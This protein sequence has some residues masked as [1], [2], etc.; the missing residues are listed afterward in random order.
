MRMRRR[1]DLG[2]RAPL[3]KDMPTTTDGDDREAHAPHARGRTW[4]ARLRQCWRRLPAGARRHAV[5]TIQC[6][7]HTQRHKQDVNTIARDYYGAL[8][9][10]DHTADAEYV[11]HADSWRRAYA[12]VYGVDHESGDP[13]DHAVLRRI[14]ASWRFMWMCRQPIADVPAIPDAIVHGELALRNGDLV[15]G[16]FRVCRLPLASEQDAS[17]PSGPTLSRDRVIC[18]ISASMHF[19][20]ARHFAG[21][22]ETGDDTIYGN[23][24]TN[25]DGYDD[26]DTVD[27]TRKVAHRAGAEGG[28]AAVDT[29]EG[30]DVGDRRGSGTTC[31]FDKLSWLSTQDS[32]FE[33]GGTHHDGASNAID[34]RITTI[35]QGDIGQKCQVTK[36]AL[37]LVPHGHAAAV[38]IDG[39]LIEGSFCMGLLHGHGRTVDARGEIFGQWRHGRLHG[40]AV[41]ITQDGWFVCATWRDGRLMGDYFAHAAHGEQ[42][43]CKTCPDGRFDGRC[44]RGYPGGDWAIERWSDGT[45]VG[46]DGFRIA[47]V[48]GSDNLA[49]GAVLDD[50]EWT[51]D[52]V[53]GGDAGVRYDGHIYYPSDPA[54]QAFALFYNYMASEASAR[55][56][57]DQQ[58]DA[59][60]WAMWM[61]R[62]RH[63]AGLPT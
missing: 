57:T 19:A 48:A 60:V 40:R 62:R 34:D 33:C 15:R 17:I 2:D 29:C 9:R 36:A 5:D 52:R 50:C 16:A 59:F 61:A 4:Y 46:I 56:F 38:G 30:D 21:A 1:S 10:S 27:I 28:T 42:F 18:P 20:K 47:P 41:A 22:T 6:N 45:L 63:A 49:E 44:R 35:D 12:A 23:D 54:S 25:G 7:E 53:R 37:A 13:M 55:A 32:R 58:R 51:C 24:N 3:V 11:M 31:D 8:G 14:G 43:R 26:D 39:S